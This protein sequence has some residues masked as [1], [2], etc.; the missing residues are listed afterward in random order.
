M[1]LRFPS[2]GT[3]F[4]KR[5]SHTHSLALIFVVFYGPTKVGPLEFLHFRAAGALSI[6]A[7]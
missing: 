2:R 5:G 4:G 6:E 3:D 1:D 7:V